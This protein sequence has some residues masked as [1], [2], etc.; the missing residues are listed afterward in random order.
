MP[1]QHFTKTIW[2]EV[3]KIKKR[4]LLKISPQQ[5]FERKE[6]NIFNKRKEVTNLFCFVFFSYS[7]LFH[8]FSFSFLSRNFL[9]ILLAVVVLLKWIPLTRVRTLQALTQWLNS[10]ALKISNQYLNH[11][12]KIL[13][14]SFLPLSLSHS[15]SHSNLD[16]VD[17]TFLTKHKAQ[18]THNT[19]ER[20]ATQNKDSDDGLQTV[21][22]LFWHLS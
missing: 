11:T 8:F 12:H 17:S 22:L 15:H 4:I 5:T 21:K 1:C 20:S 7:L 19:W 13:Y 6:K 18:N 2:A 16:T 10:Y 9:L 14:L 3:D